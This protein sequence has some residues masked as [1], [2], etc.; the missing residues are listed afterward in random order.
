M[1]QAEFTEKILKY[2]LCSEN[3]SEN[4]AVYGKMWKN[5]VEANSPQLTI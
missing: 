2:I 3:F 5:M 4:R 1:L